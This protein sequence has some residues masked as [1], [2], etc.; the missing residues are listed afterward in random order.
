MPLIRGTYNWTVFETFGGNPDT[1]EILNTL[2]K[3]QYKEGAPDNETSIGFCKWNDLTLLPTSDDTFL[4]DGWVVLGIRIDSKKVPKAILDLAFKDYMKGI[5]DPKAVDKKEVMQH[6]KKQLLP[7]IP[8]TPSLSNVVWHRPTARLFTDGSLSG[9]MNSNLALLGIKTLPINFLSNESL[10]KISNEEYLNLQLDATKIPALVPLYISIMPTSELTINL[11]K[12]Q[13]VSFIGSDGTTDD[14][15][16]SILEKGG[17]ISKMK[18]CLNLEDNNYTLTLNT[19]TPN[20]FKTNPGELKG[21]SYDKLF[22]RLERI[23]ALTYILEN[24]LK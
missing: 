19:N 4:S 18:V 7:T 8:F 23:L 5:F 16:H 22:H 3:F 6:L 14:E 21:G 15:L 1:S 10:K 24:E 9:W 20:T 12:P 2:L 17:T 13:K 11:E